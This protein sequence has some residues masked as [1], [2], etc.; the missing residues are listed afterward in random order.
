MSDER[1][2]SRGGDKKF[3][4]VK[5]A[6]SPLPC[7]GMV[8]VSRYRGGVD[9]LSRASS[10]A[11]SQG[12]GMFSCCFLLSQQGSTMVNYDHLATMKLQRSKTMPEVLTIE[13]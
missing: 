12:A 1:R 7:I 3:S 13:Q 9:A 10:L 5:N 4:I 8:Q 11:D 6:T 2:R